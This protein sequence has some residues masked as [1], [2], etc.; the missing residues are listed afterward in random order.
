MNK[1][2]RIESNGIIMEIILSFPIAHFKNNNVITSLKHIKLHIASILS[3]IIFVMLVTHNRSII[4]VYTQ[5]SLD[6]T[7][8]LWEVH[9]RVVEFN[10][11]VYIIC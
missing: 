4:S 7:M 8:T 10:S 11:K 2:I 1:L 3:V 6:L 5:V 9:S